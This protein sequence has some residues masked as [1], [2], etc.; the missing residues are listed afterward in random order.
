MKL[1]E[2]RI[3]SFLKRKSGRIIGV[4]DI[5]DHFRS[6][7]VGESTKEYLERTKKYWQHID[8]FIIGNHDAVL[9]RKNKDKFKVHNI[10]REGPVLALHG[11]QL[12]FSFEQAKIMKYEDKWHTEKAGPSLFWDAEEWICKKFNKYFNLRGEKAY[13]QAISNL[14][15][16][17]KHG[18]LTEEINT[19]ITGHTHLPFRER[20]KYK[21]KEYRVVNCGSSL[22]GKKFNPIY[23]EEID[24]WFVS[25]LHLGTSKSLLN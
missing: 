20:V 13:A 15:E 3:V 19:I 6:S 11:H 8:H 25:D 17:D 2:K 22:H 12:K 7:V 5:F 14:Q 4:G 21:G 10:Y 23:V 9:L 16:L 1:T 18:L 24:K